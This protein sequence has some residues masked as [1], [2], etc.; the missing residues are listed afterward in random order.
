MVAQ[1]TQ[2]NPF[3]PPPT[4]LKILQDPE[5]ADAIQRINSEAGVFLGFAFTF[6]AVQL[7]AAGANLVTGHPAGPWYY[8]VPLLL[9]SDFL[10][11][12]FTL[13]AIARFDF[14]FEV[15]RIYR[16]W[17]TAKEILN[18]NPAT[19]DWFPRWWYRLEEAFS[20]RIP[21]ADRTVLTRLLE[22][23]API[24]QAVIIAGLVTVLGG[25]NYFALRGT[26]LL[27]SV[28]GT[29]NSSVLPPLSGMDLTLVLGVAGLIGGFVAVFVA[30]LPQSLEWYYER[31]GRPL[32][33]EV[34]SAITK[35]TSAQ[36]GLVRFRVTN[37]I[38]S[39]VSV[40]VSPMNQ[41]RLE[42]TELV[43]VLF[44]RSEVRIYPSNENAFS[45][46]LPGK[47]SREVQLE[48]YVR[49]GLAEGRET[50]SPVVVASRFR[51]QQVYLGPFDFVLG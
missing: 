5:T 42:G 36:Y 17:P 30:I 48:Y 14:G 43:G 21:A 3:P 45:F 13:A 34:V 12:V 4:L 28:I 46:W 24:R 40:Q 31:V 26:G 47:D 49:E 23:I 19:S 8:L 1:K 29:V 11:A 33:V 15:A 25:T 51:A 44:E 18:Q 7:T 16:P 39:A 41:Y 2:P 20:R 38:R 9:V 50:V 10:T 32:R 22:W 6:Y 27:T 35:V 37:R